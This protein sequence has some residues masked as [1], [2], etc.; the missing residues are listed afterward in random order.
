MK[1]RVYHVDVCVSQTNVR[2]YFSS[3]RMR[4]V[5]CMMHPQIIIRS[6]RRPLLATADDLE[7]T[8]MNIAYYTELKDFLVIWEAYTR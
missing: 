8:R 3:A 1:K 4:K 2:L 6:G 7:R 5:F